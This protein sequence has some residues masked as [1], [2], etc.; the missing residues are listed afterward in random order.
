MN[1]SLVRHAAA[2]SAAAAIAVACAETLNHPITHGGLEFHSRPSIGLAVFPDDGADVATLL[3]H[4]DT[5]MYQAKSGV[6]GSVVT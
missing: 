1:S 3:K 6:S 4:A 5:A 2:R